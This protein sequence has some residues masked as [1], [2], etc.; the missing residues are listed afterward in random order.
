[1]EIESDVVSYDVPELHG[2]DGSAFMDNLERHLKFTESKYVK[3]TAFEQRRL[4]TLQEKQVIAGKHGTKGVEGLG[5]LTATIPAREF[6]RWRQ[7]LG[8]DCWS[9]NHFRKSFFR[10]NPEFKVDNYQ[11]SFI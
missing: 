9:D 7:D 3:E 11:K 8:D 4:E 1:M 2:K 5:Q 6:F 10:D